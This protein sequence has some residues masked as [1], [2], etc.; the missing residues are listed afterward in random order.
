M[1]VFFTWKLKELCGWNFYLRRASRVVQW[2]RFVL[3]V[4]LSVTKIFCCFNGSICTSYLQNLEN[5]TKGARFQSYLKKEFAK[6]KK[7]ENINWKK[8]GRHKLAQIYYQSNKGRCLTMSLSV[9]DLVAIFAI[10]SFFS[11]SRPTTFKKWA[12]SLFWK[13]S[14]N[15]T[16]SSAWTHMWVAMAQLRGHEPSVVITAYN[17]SK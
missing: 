14:I 15:E 1:K 10:V 11:S 5:L 2:G 17:N 4:A 16:L 6:I 7:I 8:A 12:T 3:H 13:L 9:T